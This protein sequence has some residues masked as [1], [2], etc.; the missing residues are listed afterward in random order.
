MRYA[1]VIAAAGL[2]SRMHNFKPMM[3][4]SNQTIITSVIRALK[5]AGVEEIVVVTGYRAEIL[6]RHVATLGVRTIRNTAYAETK[7]F[8]S[9]LLG[10]KQIPE[11]YDAVFVAPS[12]VPLVSPKTIRL[13]QRVQADVV[14][15]TC[16][17]TA[18][19]PVLLQMSC[20]PKIMSYCGA[21]G[22]H[23]AIETLGLTTQ[24]VEVGDVGILLDADTPQD[25]KLLRK[26]ELRLT[27]D[28]RLWP[29]LHVNVVKGDTVITPETAQLLEM[30]EH[31]GS[32]QSACHCVHIS[33]TKGWKTLNAVENALNYPLVKRSQ[34]GIDGGGTE[35]TA[36]GQLFLQAYQ[37]F[38]DEMHAAAHS[39]FAKHFS[40]DMN[41]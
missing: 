28:G 22:L 40:K 37:G 23:G 34:G 26:A 21:Q 32:I 10:L 17:E 8:D 20:I 33:Y 15:P 19:H 24:D 27:S 6:E 11:D 31:T 5:C 18:G 9:L 3:C 29:D 14:R 7:M 25:Y 4:L 13:M 38:Q 16:R 39:L 12:D 2:S 41:G 1:A 30:I 35:L 36:M